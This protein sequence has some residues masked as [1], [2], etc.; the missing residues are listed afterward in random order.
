M[1]DVE[2]ADSPQDYAGDVV[3]ES[4]RSRGKFVTEESNQLPLI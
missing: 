4:L 3:L 2:A 1:K